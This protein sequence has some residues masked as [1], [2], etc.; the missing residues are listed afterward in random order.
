MQRGTAGLLLTRH[1]SG[2]PARAS[3]DKEGEKPA[4]RVHGAKDDKGRPL[5]GADTIAFLL[6]KRVCD[7]GEEMREK[8]YKENKTKRWPFGT[9]S[10]VWAFLESVLEEPGTLAAVRRAPRL[11]CWSADTLRK[12][13]NELLAVFG[14]TPD[15]ALHKVIESPSLL[16]MSLDGTF[17]EKRAMLLRRGF[18][19][20]AFIKMVTVFPRFVH[21]SSER[22]KVT[23][24][25]L[26]QHVDD[27]VRVLSAQPAIFSFTVANLD[28]KVAFLRFMGYD[29]AST[30]SRHAC[31][32]R[33]TT[34]GGH[35]LTLTRLHFCWRKACGAR[36]RRCAM[37]FSGQTRIHVGRWAPP[38]LSGVSWSVFLRSQVLWQ[39]C[40][41]NHGCSAG[42]RTRCAKTGTPC[43]LSSI[44][45]LSKRSAR[46]SNHLD[47]SR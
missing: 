8:L 47:F 18:S 31:T 36:R 23:I 46:S 11:L 28:D 22:L 13:W 34:K 29:A 45:R 26:S 4:R 39:P 17:V 14:W 38:P 2:G 16:T 37:S 35:W 40:A 3:S 5:V 44:G 12:N 43:R 41:D 9:V 27:P 30:K 24:V 20:E 10:P 33:D 7:T 32:G 25:W 6:E 42:Q 21:C 1:S 19:D 15:E